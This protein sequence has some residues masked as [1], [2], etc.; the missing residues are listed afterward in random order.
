MK[1]NL[2]II[3]LLAAVGLFGCVHGHRHNRSH[4]YS[5]IEI[6]DV[7]GI[8]RH[9][10]PH[11]SSYRYRRHYHPRR[12]YRSHHRHYRY[13]YER[14]RRRSYRERDRYHRRDMRRRNVHRRHRRR[15][16]R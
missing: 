13:S 7:V 4:S 6:G 1:K 10:R 8:S 12:H 11:R 14:S 5:V 9:Y 3:V 15:N 2:S 16:R